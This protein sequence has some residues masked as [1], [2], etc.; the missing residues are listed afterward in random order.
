MTGLRVC[1]VTLAPGRVELAPREV[2]L[3]EWF[4]ESPPID[5]VELG[6]YLTEDEQDR[7]ARYKV[8][9]VRRQFVT[10][11]G[12]LRLILGWQ[13][14]LAPRAVPIG[15]TGAGKPVLIDE[16]AGLHFSVTHA[17]G[18]GLIALAREPVGVDAERVRALADPEGLVRRFFSPAECATYLSLPAALRP[19]GFFR[20]W[21]CKEAVIKAVGLSVINLDGFDV[22]LHPERPA[23][24]L[25]ARHPAVCRGGWELASW[26]A[27]PGYAAAVA[28]RV[29]DDPV[30]FARLGCPASRHSV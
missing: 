12:L 21:T 26:E 28:L 23:A 6:G 19:L 17:E 16:S 7:A 22:E 30:C 27:T 8:D 5:P 20:A 2:R 3:W 11:R 24:V 29:Q 18:Y 9:R 4:L 15:Y 14:G 13:L 25:A 10:G 1:P